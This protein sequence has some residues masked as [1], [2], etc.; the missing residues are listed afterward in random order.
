MPRFIFLGIFNFSFT[1]IN[2]GKKFVYAHFFR[3]VSVEDGR[4]L[5]R[6]V[7][8]QLPLRHVTN[9]FGHL[10]EV[11]LVVVAVCV[12]VDV[13]TS[14]VVVFAAVVVSEPPL[15]PIK[16][17][18]VRKSPATAI[19]DSVRSVVIAKS[20]DKEILFILIISNCNSR[21]NTF[22]QVAD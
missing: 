21:I 16:E 7:H 2:R 19:T 1:L 5:L 6:I 17:Q 14:A 11:E 10:V 3:I 15:P 9:L 4:L 13:V 22:I 8:F 12:M 18:P 20:S